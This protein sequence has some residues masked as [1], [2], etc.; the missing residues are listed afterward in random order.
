MKARLAGNCFACADG[1]KS[2]FSMAVQDVTSDEF[3]NR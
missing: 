2:H 1:S 3:V